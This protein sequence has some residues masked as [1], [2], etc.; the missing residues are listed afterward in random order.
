MATKL[1]FRGSRGI[2]T[3]ER[4]R[5]WYVCQKGNKLRPQLRWMEDIISKARLL[6]AAFEL[7]RYELFV[8]TT[9]TRRRREQKLLGKK[10]E[11]A[12]ELQSCFFGAE[13]WR[14]M[15][16]NVRH[17]NPHTNEDTFE[18]TDGRV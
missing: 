7:A 11:N 3:P 4:I 1:V 9:C 10:L 14:E 16:A 15:N 18:W 6:A 12:T 5:P 8:V 17:D 2:V 13:R